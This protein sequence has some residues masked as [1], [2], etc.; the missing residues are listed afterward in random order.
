[1]TKKKDIQTEKSNE[2]KKKL[3][4]KSIQNKKQRD[5]NSNNEGE[6][7]AAIIS[8]PSSIVEL[9][10]QKVNK[11]REVLIFDNNIEELGIKQK[12][13]LKE[14]A[15]IIKDKPVK[16]VIKTSISKDEDTR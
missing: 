4:K 5:K 10:E 8:K 3:E 16:I 7:L 11:K 9:K 15:L 13:K 6:M 14:F 1:M 12:K 2:G